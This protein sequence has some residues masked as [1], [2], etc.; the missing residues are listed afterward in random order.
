MSFSAYM[1]PVPM[2]PPPVE[3]LGYAIKWS[4]ARRFLNGDGGSRCEPI[5]LTMEYADWLYGLVHSSLPENDLPQEALRL[6][7]AIGKYG[8]VW[9]WI[10]DASDAP[11][12]GGVVA[13]DDPEAQAGL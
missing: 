1:Q 8:E 9:V 10:G 7:D 5:K 6:L 2:Q 13:D 4:I 12:P 11:L 3:Y